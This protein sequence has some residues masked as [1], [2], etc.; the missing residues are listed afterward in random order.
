MIERNCNHC[1]RCCHEVPCAVA[2]AFAGADESKPCKALNRVGDQ[3]FC[4]IFTEPE[5]YIDVSWCKGDMLIEAAYINQAKEALMPMMVGVCDSVY[6]QE[7][8]DQRIPI[9]NV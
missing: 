6:G 7:D 1:G 4:G 2:M 3:Y 8:K 5:S 9:H